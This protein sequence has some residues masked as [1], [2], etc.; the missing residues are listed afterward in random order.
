MAETLRVAVQ[1]ALP[2]LA[3]G[4]I[5]RRPAAMAVAGKLQFDRPAVRLLRHLRDRHY[6]RP[7]RLRVP[8]RTVELALS[9]A[10]VKRVLAGAPTPFS[11]QWRSGRR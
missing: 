8:G 10:D 5:K 6:G 11:P 3:R 7:L 2:T 9:G 4:V 1:V